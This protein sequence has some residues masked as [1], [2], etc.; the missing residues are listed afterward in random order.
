M[1]I[2]ELFKDRSFFKGLFIIAIPIM[3]QNLVNSFVNMVDTVMIGQL[4][5]AEI[6][7]VG[8]ANN[9]F[10][11]LNMLLFGAASG[12]GVF[13]AQFWGKKDI[14]GIRKNTGLCI[15][16]VILISSFFTI[17]SLFAPEK[18]LR[19]YTTD[20]DV[21]KIGAEYLRTVAPCFIPF[22]ISFVF[23]LVMR[24]IEKVK[25]AMVVTIISLSV[26]VLFNWLLIFGIGPFPTLGV[27]GA[28]IATVLART[29]EVIL[30][31]SISYSKKICVSRNTQ[32]T[33]RLRRSLCKTLFYN[34]IAC[35]Y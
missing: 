2:S 20:Q 30:L 35:N 15:V 7:G 4:G 11:L 17:V 21:I 9:F 18:V 26:N 10:F 13:T 32:R 27:K 29:I 1:K 22:A 19:L 33:V 24:T 14:A 31:V 16:I 6:A 28:A 23:T 5:T 3:L 8:L 34:S 25:L 12:A